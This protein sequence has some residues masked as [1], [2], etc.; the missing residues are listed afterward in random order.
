MR[1]RLF[2]KSQVLSVREFDEVGVSSMV[3]RSTS[4]IAT[5][6][7]T[8]G[9]V[10]QL[11][12]PAPILAAASVG[13]TIHASPR[14]ALVLIVS[15]AVFL[16][17]AALMLKLSGR[18]SRQIQVRLDRINQVVREAVTG[19]RVIPGPSATRTMRRSDPAGPIGI[20]RIP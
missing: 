15:V 3:T 9:L 11:V 4:D 20:T 8:V 6:Q 7:T 16:A 1:A 12:I 5:M 10:L 19:T 13:M 14:L 17:F 18:L 2:R